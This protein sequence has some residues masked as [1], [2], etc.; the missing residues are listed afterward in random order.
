MDTLSLSKKRI[1]SISFEMTNRCNLFC[2]Y[3]I[4]NSGGS[5][6]VDLDKWNYY[7]AIDDIVES[8]CPIEVVLTGGEFTIRDDWHEIISVTNRKGVDPAII[9]NATL[10]KEDDFSFLSDCNIRF[11]QVSIDGLNNNANSLR[12]NSDLNII[13]KNLDNISKY[14]FANKVVMRATI[15]TLNR[16]NLSEYIKFACDR[17]FSVRFGLLT[18]QGRAAQNYSASDV[19][20][21]ASELLSTVNELENLKKQYSNTSIETPTFGAFGGCPMIQD[22]QPFQLSVSAHGNIYPCYE[23]MIKGLEIGNIKDDNLTLSMQTKKAIDILGFLTIRA[24]LMKNKECAS[25]PGV[26]V[27]RGG[28]AANGLASDRNA[29]KIN[30]TACKAAKLHYVFSN[31][32]IFQSNSEL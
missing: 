10:F 12:K 32:N 7:K 15:T 22:K 17:G 4:R 1:E 11:L 5:N 27:C 26:N 6:N 14:T 21:S 3:C 16:N 25:C 9:T 2:S 13:I 30:E 23:L 8:Q 31:R 24:E 29:F 18:Y 19:G 28:C 20:L